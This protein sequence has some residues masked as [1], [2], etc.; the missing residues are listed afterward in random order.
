MIPG[1]D[2]LGSAWVPRVGDP[3][4]FGWAVA[5]GY[6]LAAGLAA[7]AWRGAMR[8]TLVGALLLL[9]LN[10]QLDVQTGFT[11]VAK[12][13]ALA[14]G[15]YYVRRPFQIGFA[16]AVLAGAAM[17]MRALARRV[18][19]G[20]REVGP[21]LAG[22]ACL[23]LFVALRAAQVQHL[24]RWPGMDALP[25]GVIRALEPLGIVLIAGH[26]A[27]RLWLRGGISRGSRA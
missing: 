18:W 5:G 24:D 15:W 10:K 3:T 20:P 12:C 14:Q 6:G 17:V 11:A 9:M 1:L 25:M 22:L 21:A 4:A 7:L 16:L 2:C 19:R 26:A 8:W 27:V 13:M 23:I